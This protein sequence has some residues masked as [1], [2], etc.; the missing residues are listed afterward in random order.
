MDTIFFQNLLY[1]TLSVFVVFVTAAFAVCAI[2]IIKALR[3]I[4]RVVSMLRQEG[5]KVAADIEQFRASARS[6]GVKF[7]SF[8]L[9]VL[10][11]LNHHKKSKSKNSKN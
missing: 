5:E 2:Y 1:L 4:H 11:F 7:A 8:M 6:G 10:S 9:S 3:A